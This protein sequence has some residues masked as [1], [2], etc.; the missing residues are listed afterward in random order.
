MV[1][2][3]LD[4]LSQL[5]QDG[6]VNVL[7]SSRGFHLKVHHAVDRPASVEVRHGQNAQFFIGF[8]EGLAGFN[9]S[10]HDLGIGFSLLL[11]RLGGKDYSVSRTANNGGEVW[12]ERLNHSLE[13]RAFK[14]S[15]A[16]QEAHRK[17]AREFRLL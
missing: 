7:E 10:T 6:I 13:K 17:K 2:S 8:G 12:L 15:A 3:F 16:L 9:D 4:L 5:L 1:G 14:F 11:G